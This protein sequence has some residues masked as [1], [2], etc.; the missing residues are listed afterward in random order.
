MIRR[1]CG[2]SSSA[3]VGW[4][5]GKK[6][7]QEDYYGVYSKDNR[8]LFAAADGIGGHSWGHLASRWMVEELVKAF[9]ENTNAAEMFRCGVEKA[10][11][12]MEAYEKDM[13]CTFTASIIEQVQAKFKLSYS[14]IG[15]SRLYLLS[16]NINNKMPP[17]AK[18]I[19]RMKN[20]IFWLLT[21]DDSFVW[22]FLQKGELT[23]DQITQHPDK[24]YLER[25]VHPGQKNLSVLAER[26]AK[27]IDIDKHD[28]IFLCTDGIWET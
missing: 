24:S 9:L 11:S 3:L 19:T 17:G 5:K 13:G 12:R 25:S 8:V 22:G 2:D 26:R 27:T 20:R 28:T 6:E 18:E 16:S 21:E 7:Y 15:D 10:V 23:L 1:Q 14:W 4:E